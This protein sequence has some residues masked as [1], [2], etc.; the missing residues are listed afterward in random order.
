MLPLYIKKLPKRPRKKMIKSSY[1][2][3]KKIKLNKYL[4]GSL[5]HHKNTC[6]NIVPSQRNGD[7]HNMQA[8]EIP[9]MKR[10]NHHIF[11]NFMPFQ[12][13]DMQAE[14]L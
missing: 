5:G 6:K 1:E 12:L 10:F 4:R 7:S 3:K 8:E 13:M 2:T 11:I 14:K 9:T